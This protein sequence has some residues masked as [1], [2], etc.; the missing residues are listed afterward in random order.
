MSA[1]LPA[2]K[3]RCQQILSGENST[4]KHFDEIMETK[5]A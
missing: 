1:M 4:L 2:A 5:Q 3:M